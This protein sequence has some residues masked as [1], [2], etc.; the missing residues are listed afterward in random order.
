MV[1]GNSE[2]EGDIKKPKLLKY[3]PKFKISR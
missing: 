1:V 2:E 3:E